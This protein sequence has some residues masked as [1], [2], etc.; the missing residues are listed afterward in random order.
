MIIPQFFVAK[1]G[2]AY[3]H[4]PVSEAVV[5]VR[6][7]L[8]SLPPPDE[9]VWPWLMIYLYISLAGALFSLFYIFAHY[10]CGALF[11]KVPKF[12]AFEASSKESA[13]L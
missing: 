12:V 3:E 1:W 7:V 6:G 5:N 13:K 10:H 9:N 4:G 2:E 11:C 8:D